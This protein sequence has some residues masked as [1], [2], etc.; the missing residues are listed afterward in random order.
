[1]LLVKLMTM[2]KRGAIFGRFDQ[3]T[4]IQTDVA[5]IP[6][7]LEIVRQSYHSGTQEG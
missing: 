7:I 3:T 2:R 4:T 1:M 5:H 6:V